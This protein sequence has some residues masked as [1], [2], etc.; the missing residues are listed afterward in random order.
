MAFLVMKEK[1][2]E[3]LFAPTR[4]VSA[5]RMREVLSECRRK[6]SHFIC[7]KATIAGL[8]VCCRGYYDIQPPSQLMRIAGRLRM[9]E[10]ID[11]SELSTG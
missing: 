4:I 5:E 10:F 11:E 6:D 2:D 1:C 7:H 8:D 3:C 9:I